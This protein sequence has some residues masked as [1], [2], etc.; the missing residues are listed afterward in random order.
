MTV[1]TKAQVLAVIRRARGPQAAESVAEQIPET[2]DTDDPKALELLSHLGF[3]RDQ[4]FSDLGG[5]I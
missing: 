2:L 5:A 4:I 1:L 3:T